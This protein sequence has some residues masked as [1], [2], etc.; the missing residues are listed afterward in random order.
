MTLTESETHAA[1]HV[2]AQMV[3]QMGEK[4]LPKFRDM[5]HAVRKATIAGRYLQ[6]CQLPKESKNLTG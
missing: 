4:D 1:W 5:I 2:L 6:R 3:E